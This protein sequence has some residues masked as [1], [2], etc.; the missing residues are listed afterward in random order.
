MPENLP[1]EFVPVSAVGGIREETLPRVFAQHP[2]ELALRGDPEVRERAALEVGDQGVL[3]C[4]P[5]FDEAPGEALLRN[6]VERLQSE[7]V[8]L[9]PLAIHPGQRSI[10]V[11]EDPDLGRT[12]TVIVG[13]ED[14][15]EERSGRAR[16]MR[17]QC[18]QSRCS[19]FHVR[20]SWEQSSPPSYWIISF[21][22]RQY[23]E[24]PV[25][26]VTLGGSAHLVPYQRPKPDRIE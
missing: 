26:A 22:F 25:V 14:A 1:A 11:G 21:L 8:G 2:E 19:F 20:L 5:A 18:K 6:T 15:L 10:D 4:R 24:D 9:D 23:C 7:A 13:G 12:R 16:L 17:V 3:P